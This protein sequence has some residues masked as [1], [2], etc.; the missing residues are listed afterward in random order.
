M[1]QL[2][3]KKL[4][5]ALERNVKF[6][7]NIFP[8]AVASKIIPYL[9]NCSFTKQYGNHIGQSKRGTKIIRKVDFQNTA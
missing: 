5:P 4:F 9:Q 3:F 7:K 8:V 1:F 6:M 2:L